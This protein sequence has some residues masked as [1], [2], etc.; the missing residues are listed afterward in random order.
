V[1]RLE[2]TEALRSIAADAAV[3]A[4]A[5]AEGPLDA[6]VPGCPGW[7]LRELVTH[8]GRIHRWVVEAVTT[9]AAPATFPAR[10]DDDE[11]LAAWF[12]AGAKRL[13]EVL[14]GATP[15]GA[16]WTLMGPG[17]VDFWWT[18]QA[19]ETAVHRVDAESA[20]GRPSPIDRAVAVAGVDELLGAF[21]P[22]LVLRGAVPLDGESLHLHATDGEGE[23]LVR[24]V[25]GGLE[26]SR[27]H[28]KGDAAVRAPASALLLWLYNRPAAGG[29]E[30]L[31]DADVAER[32]RT[33]LRI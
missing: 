19:V 26:V 7:L 31:G 14:A 24:L 23:W 13:V 22:M 30:V 25:G 8:T 1:E 33:Q 9:T 11:D 21:G 15:G 28:A 10:P 5:V 6:E 4:A 16:C 12:R 18:R 17:T 29:V 27:E 20:L 2:R 3:M 32:W